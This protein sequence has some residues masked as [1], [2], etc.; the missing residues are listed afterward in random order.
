MRVTD[1]EFLGLKIN[2]N[3]LQPSDT[4][5][6]AVMSFRRPSNESEV[7]SFLGLA[8]YMGKFIP[9]LA[10]IDEPLR[11]TERGCVPLGRCRRKCV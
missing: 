3:G 8:N 4:K 6:D 5:R 9:N 1:F 10:E 2:S 11:N 7:R